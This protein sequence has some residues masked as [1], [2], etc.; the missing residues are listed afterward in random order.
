MGSFHWTKT[1]ETGLSEV[2]LQH[3]YLVDIL[4]EFGAILVMDQV[5]PDDIKQVFEKLAGK[6]YVR[7]R[8]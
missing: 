6:N 8:V 5:A 4:N 7:T 3:R 2:D 1:Y